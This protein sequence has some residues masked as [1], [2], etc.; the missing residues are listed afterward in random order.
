[1]PVQLH[2]LV[3]GLD[4]VGIGHRNHHHREEHE[5]GDPESGGVWKERGGN[6][7]ETRDADM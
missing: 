7:Q 3:L 6:D 4:E 1:M 5:C 2:S